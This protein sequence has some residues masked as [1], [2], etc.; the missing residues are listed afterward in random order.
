MPVSRRALPLFAIASILLILA[1]SVYPIEGEFIRGDSNS[2]GAIELT[3]GVFTLIQS[4]NFKFDP[5]DQES[6]F[7]AFAVTLPDGTPLFFVGCECF[8][9]DLPLILY[10]GQEITQPTMFTGAT[11]SQDSS[12]KWTLQFDAG[13]T[14][15]GTT[16][17]VEWIYDSSCGCQYLSPTVVVP[18]GHSVEGMLGN[19]DGNPDNDL[20][21]PD[22][23]LYTNPDEFGES[24]RVSNEENLFDGALLPAM[25]RWGWTLLFLLLAGAG[26][27]VTRR[28]PLRIA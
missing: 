26:L 15:A 5:K 11:L 25:S 4:R 1:T 14:H 22:G 16:F 6:Y 21:G 20:T 27:L 2:D 10:E 13:P 7:G 19:N 24:W 3:D 23:T 18:P 12:T 9:P 8:D 28:R 17:S